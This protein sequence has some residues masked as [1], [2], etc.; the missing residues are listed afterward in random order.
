M[1]IRNLKTFYKIATLGS[2]SKAAEALGYAQSTLTFHIQEIEAH[3]GQPVFE[4]TGRHKQLTAFGK[5]LLE[6]VEGLLHTY[7]TLEHL[8]NTSEVLRETLRIGAPESLMMY[9]LFPIIKEYKSLY[10]QV[11]V[12]VTNARCPVL[13]GYLL[14][15][16]LDVSIMLQ[17]L[18]NYPN[19][20]VVSL[21][22]E[23]MCLVAPQ[24]HERDDLL[25]GASQ[26]ILHVEAECTYRQEFERFLQAQHY[27]PENI[28]E[29]SSV[30]AIKKYILN[31][32]GVSYLPYYSVRDEAK[33]GLVRVRFPET[34]LRFFTQIVSPSNKWRSP[35]MKAFIDLCHVYGKQWELDEGGETA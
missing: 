2:F 33:K 26:M 10:P 32:M 8:G 18:C 12:T 14:S 19:L 17:P 23:R 15:G 11:N 16:Q 28:L 13:R 6:Q 5:Q 1:E 22:E 34:N 3:Y 9:R 27:V 24:G 31:G 20:D 29:T 25:P 4:K 35:A 7:D 30:E 21:R